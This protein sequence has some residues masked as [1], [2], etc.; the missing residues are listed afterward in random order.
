MTE[1]VVVRA[2]DRWWVTVGRDCRPVG[3]DEV[4]RLVDES[5][6]TLV[7]GTRPAP[8]V[9]EV[10]RMPFVAVA[11]CIAGVVTAD[12]LLVETPGSGEAVLERGD[13][14]LLD[15]VVGHCSPESLLV[16]GRLDGLARLVALGVVQ[17]AT[18][19]TAGHARGPRAEPGAP[20]LSAV[21]TPAPEGPSGRVPVYAIWHSEVGP[22]LSLGM[23]T[24]SARHH[25][26]G[27][28]NEVYEIRRPESAASFLEDLADRQGPAVL[29]CSDYV[30]TLEENL[31]AARRAR[32]LNPQVFV[33]HGGPSSPKYPGDAEDFLRRHGDAADVLTRGEG[34]QLIVEL[35]AALATTLP[36]GDP[37]A[38]R[39]VAGL[40]FRDPITH[41]IVRTP[42]RERIVDLDALPSPYL[43]GEFDH[44]PAEQWNTC[45]SIETNRGCPYG[46][47]FCDWGSS[48]LSR[49]RKFDLDRVRAE[50]DWVGAR[51][52]NSLNLTDA[53]FGILSR[54]VATA[55]HLAATKRATGAPRLVSFYPAKNTTRHLTKI[56]DAIVGAGISTAA[57]ISLQTSDPATLEAID[58]SNIATEHYVALAADYRRRG[59]PLQGDL[60]LGLPGQT[61]ESFR[62]DL[63]FNFDHEIMARTWQVHTLVNSPMNDPAYRE[64]YAVETEDNLVVATA[65]F[66]RADRERMLALRRVDII[67]ERYG[68]LRHVLRWVQWDHGLAA[69]EV[70]D[71]L[72]AVA[73]DEPTRHPRLAWLFAHFPH[74]AAPLVGW[75]GL[76]AEVRSIL[77]ERVGIPPSS[78][79]DTVLDLQQFLMPRAGR[80]FPDT[81]HLAHD[82]LTYYRSATESLFT[83]GQAGG[84]TAALSTHPVSELTIDGDPIG[85]CDHG[86][87]FAQWGRA[88]EMEGDFSIGANTAFELD[89]P[90]LRFLPHVAA[91]GMRPRYLGPPDATPTSE[92]ELR[93]G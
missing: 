3:L 8:R 49:I 31:D 36:A 86:M 11:P 83:T 59:L 75:S 34:E 21:G 72:M 19:A 18:A 28:L 41:E 92:V 56:V 22:L 60:L 45:L 7:E 15:R 29:L 79:L 47:T 17:S 68:V 57:S 10:G 35:L 4:L 73:D 16:D 14:A 27:V 78:A 12:G 55:T 93:V 67:L 6:R 58:R 81:I 80:Q 71:L 90:L 69:T 64:R 74:F 61:Y 25:D 82:Y 24:A 23:L 51:G 88:G 89:S 52:I 54:D 62:R 63:Q 33:V 87:R 76:Y 37:A 42:D 70:M 20:R 2:D 1:A 66:S 38:L 85:L 39:A 46:C 40:T 91:V 13:L 26:G 84:P 30:W 44:I 53:N 77:V 48:T 5:T 65:S 50:I 32:Q 9:E 43:T